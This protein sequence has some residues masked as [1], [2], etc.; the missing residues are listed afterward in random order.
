MFTSIIDSSTS[1]I[2][3][4]T[5]LICMAAAL[6]LGFGVAAVYRITTERYTQNFLITLALLPMLVEAVILMTSGNLGTAVAVAGAFSLVRFRSVQGTSREIL[7]VFL[8][9]AIGLACGMGQITFAALFTA[10]AVL[11]LVLFSR[12]GFAGR[13]ET[14]R[15]LRITIPEDLDYTGVF[16][17]LF[18]KYTSRSTLEK[19]KTINLGSMYE[20]HFQVVLKEAAR[21]KEFLDEIRVRNG[22]LTIVCGRVADTVA[23]L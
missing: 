19:V 20:L 16:E 18:A 11:T 1:S 12:S 10:V 4:E 13:E 8:A 5:T 21:E 22:N 17:D 2:S 9:M 15:H 3:I 14:F 23:E 6:L 7:G